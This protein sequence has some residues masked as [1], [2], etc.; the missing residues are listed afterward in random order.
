[1]MWSHRDWQ[2]DWLVMMLLMSCLWVG[3]VVLVL[4]LVSANGDGRSARQGGFALA[5][6]LSDD[7]FVRE[8]AENTDG[9]GQD[10]DR[11]SAAGGQVGV[12]GPRS[13]PRA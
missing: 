3:F 10:S 2:A 7:V 6:E 1:M 11:A 4:W 13:L 5:H 9:P 8:D 12:S